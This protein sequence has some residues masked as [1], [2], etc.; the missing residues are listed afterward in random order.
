[1][2]EWRGKCTRPLCLLFAPPRSSRR[3]GHARLAQSDIATENARATEYFI[4]SLLV[5]QTDN[6]AGRLEQ[7]EYLP[8]AGVK[9]PGHGPLCSVP[10]FGATLNPAVSM[11]RDKIN[12][13]ETLRVSFKDGV[14]A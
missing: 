8:T 4:V 10:S 13:R 2:R 6:R 11:Q 3:L 5:R 12:I 9:L 1:M 14:F 7:A